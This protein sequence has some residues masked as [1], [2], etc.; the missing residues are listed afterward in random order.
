[1]RTP[2]G[3][4]AHASAAR[5]ADGQLWFAT[6]AGAA[7]FFPADVTPSLPE[8]RVR[9]SAEST[10]GT[11][12]LDGS[13]LSRDRANVHLSFVAPSFIDPAR[14]RYRYQLVGFDPDWVDAGLRREATF[15]NL[16]PGSYQFQ[17]QAFVPGSWT[18]QIATL[19]FER[20]RGLTERWFF[21]PGL[22]LLSSCVV[23][24]A[25][26]WRVQRLRRREALLE[27][28]VQERTAELTE[29][30]ARAAKSERSARIAERMAA[31]GTLAAG[32]AHELNN[33]LAFVSSNVEF[34]VRELKGLEPGT[35]PPELAE[36][37]LSAMEDAND[38]T[39]RLREIVGDLKTFSRADSGPPREVDP[40]AVLKT[41]LNLSRASIKHRA[42]IETELEDVPTVLAEEGRLAQVLVNLLVNAGQAIPEGE[43]AENVITAASRTRPDGW[44]EL[45]VRDTGCG[46][47]QEDLARIFDPFFTTKPVGVGTGLGLSICH[48]II[49]AAGGRMEVESAVGVGTRFRVLLPPAGSPTPA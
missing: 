10:D 16:P 26:W 48:G 4:G 6:M 30:L 39:R 43:N 12:I 7:H 14:I 44:A 2:E 15:T 35:L 9:V 18:S 42:R 20:P 49:E 33:P 34:A 21:Y 36:D 31:V 46:I 19:R 29:A 23:G 8:T 17:V 27:A 24:A 45:E 38:G 25:A 37:L 5:T 22:V 3:N 28:R 47:P 40:R 13:A 11:P 1:M 41:A 32:V